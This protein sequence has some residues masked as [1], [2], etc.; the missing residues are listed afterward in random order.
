MVV[1]SNWSNIV[2]NVD[3]FVDS[4]TL[5]INKRHQVHIYAAF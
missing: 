5:F 4:V 2:P 3:K 1:L